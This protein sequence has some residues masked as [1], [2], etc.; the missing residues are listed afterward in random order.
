M[1]KVLFS[2]LILFAVS[3]TTFA[4]ENTAYAQKLEQ[5]FELNGTEETYKVAIKQITSIYKQRYPEAEPDFWNEFEKDF[6]N[7][8]MIDL[9]TMF[10]PAYQKHLTLEDLDGL[11][12]FYQT[13]VGKKYAQKTPV[14]MQE[15]MQIGQEWGIK[16]GKE[17]DKKMKAKGY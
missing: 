1:K 12:A 16:L 2:I 7:T 8:S 6:S 4:Q 11:I 14:I 9:T 5:L 3:T 13:P 17:F 10:V 15:S